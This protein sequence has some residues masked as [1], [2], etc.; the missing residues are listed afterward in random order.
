MDFDLSPDQKAVHDAV[1]QIVARH[2]APRAEPLFCYYDEALDRDLAAA[3]FF[4]IAK[5]EGCGPLDAALLVER[6]A[7]A[8]GAV[9]AAA[10]SLV[11]PLLGLESEPR[12]VALVGPRL[13]DPVRYLPMARTALI[14]AGN[15]VLA[16][17]VDGNAVEA[18]ETPLAY[19]LGRFRHPPTG[20]RRLG[21]AGERLRQWWRAALAIESAGLMQA[22]L[23]TT[24]T[25]VKQR[26]QF[27][28]P[29]GAF[30]AVQHRL[31]ECAVL[32][33]ETRWLALRAAA[34]GDASE[35]AL[36]ALF[37]Q[38][39]SAK[40]CYDLHQFHGA[41]GLTLEHPL[42]FW[43]FRLKA[44]QGELG[45]ASGQASAAADLVWAPPS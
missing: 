26:R 32:A 13:S 12:P 16:M 7:T 11:L 18:I 39:A 25:Y 28:R 20:G 40:L 34:T 9:E 6:V 42:H 17:A 44:M 2:A 29:I 43:T 36:S 22:A 24:L 41:M 8:P 10:S 31:A 3:G 5:T 21:G 30:Q 23:D 33:K 1:G 27:G 37:A 35:A 14:D 4:S 45:G 38:D 15:D 19:P